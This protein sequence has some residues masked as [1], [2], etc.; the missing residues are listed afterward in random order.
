M[1]EHMSIT[2]DTKIAGI[3]RK[4]AVQEKRSL[5]QVVEIAVEAYLGRNGAPGGSIV[6]SKSSFQGSF[7]R[8][9][10]YTDRR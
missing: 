8:D 4:H 9:T 3:L 7:S 5:S 1:K 10:T 2:I 6:T